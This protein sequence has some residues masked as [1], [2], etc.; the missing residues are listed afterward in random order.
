MQ[1]EDASL[2]LKED[3][4]KTVIAVLDEDNQQY[5]QMR[6]M[7]ISQSDL[8]SPKSRQNSASG[9][10]QQPRTLTDD[11]MYVPVDGQTRQGGNTYLGSNEN[12]SDASSTN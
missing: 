4:V 5:K 12:Q 9:I 7:S 11:N 8:L 1:T 6:K 3:D 10:T 2:I